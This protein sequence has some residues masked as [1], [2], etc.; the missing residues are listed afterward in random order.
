MGDHNQKLYF[1]ELIAKINNENRLSNV[2]LIEFCTNSSTNLEDD[3]INTSLSNRN[4]E[5]TKNLIRK[6]PLNLTKL[7]KFYNNRFYKEIFDEYNYFLTNDP[8]QLNSNNLNLLTRSINEAKNLDLNDIKQ[9]INNLKEKNIDISFNSII[10]L[11]ISFI[12][13]VTILFLYWLF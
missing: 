2:D 9:L 13:K 6:S 1:N 4:R 7:N 10:D 8:T 3:Q 5:N 12:N 11:F